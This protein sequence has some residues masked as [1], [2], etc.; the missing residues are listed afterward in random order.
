MND[1]YVHDKVRQLHC[2]NVHGTI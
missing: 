1:K 2:I